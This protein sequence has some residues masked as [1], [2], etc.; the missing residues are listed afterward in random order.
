MKWTPKNW[1]RMESD[2]AYVFENIC[3]FSLQ[4]MPVD[5]TPYTESLQPKLLSGEMIS[6]RFMISKL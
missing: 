3:M 4:D 5:K 1:R 2:E 6:P